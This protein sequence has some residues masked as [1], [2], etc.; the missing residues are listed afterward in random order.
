L[1]QWNWTGTAELANFAFPDSTAFGHGIIGPASEIHGPSIP[2]AA[3]V[4]EP[5]NDTEWVF[6]GW[7]EYDDIFSGTPRHRTEFAFQ[8]VRTRPPN[9]TELCV[10]FQPLDRFN[11]I[12]GGCTR[13]FWPHENVYSD[14][15]PG[16]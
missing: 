14:R 13:P 4:F 16:A 9:S 15:Q 7:V 12:D 1:Q 10:S 11:A 6:W 5:V 3:H 8:I 2:I